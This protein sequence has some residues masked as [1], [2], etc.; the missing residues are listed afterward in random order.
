[1]KHDEDFNA[2]LDPMI[3]CVVIAALLAIF[4]IGLGL[5]EVLRALLGEWV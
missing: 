5:Y 4:G 3:G 2:E 1:M